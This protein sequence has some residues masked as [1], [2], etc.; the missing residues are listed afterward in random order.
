[1]ESCN[2]TTLTKD[3]LVLD[4]RPLPGPQRHRAIFSLFDAL[5]PGE[6]FELVNDHDPVR[7]CFQFEAQWPGL[8]GWEYLQQGPDEFRVRITHK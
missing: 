3:N 4:V 6:S 1:M 8:Y 2:V 7:L 5:R